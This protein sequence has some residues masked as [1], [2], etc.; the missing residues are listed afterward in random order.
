MKYSIPSKIKIIITNILILLTLTSL[1]AQAA[2]EFISRIVNPPCSNTKPTN[3]NGQKDP[4]LKK[5]ALYQI[6]CNSKVASELMI[7]TVTPTTQ[8]FAISQSIYLYQQI[9]AFSIVGVKPLIIME[10]SDENGELLSFRQLKNG[11]YNSHIKTLFANM[12]RLGLNSDELGT[13]VL[14]PEANTP[15]WN[16]D[17]TNPA[18]FGFIFNQIAAQIKSELPDAKLS[19]MLNSFSYANTDTEWD[20]PLDKSFLDYTRNIQRNY[21]YSV[22]IQGFGWISKRSQPNQIQLLN[23]QDYLKLEKVEELAN[24]FGTKNI[25]INTGTFGQKYTNPNDKQLISPTQRES[26]NNQLFELVRNSQNKGFRYTINSFL[27]DKL[28]TSEQTDFSL[29]KTLAER[30]AFRN[31]VRQANANNVELSI[32]DR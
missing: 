30:N 1:S 27:G 7:F 13:V 5:L 31:F 10:P 6:T 25:W 2:P 21:I 20:E 8:E 3:L 12:R 17:G 29:I 23:T 19:L 11:R 14:L 4:N 22:G 32:F 28:N 16:F 15:L 18:D 9:K 24:F 26:Q